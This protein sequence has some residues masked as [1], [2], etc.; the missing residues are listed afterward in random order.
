[1]YQEV[2]AAS[3]SPGGGIS[4]TTFSSCGGSGMDMR[5]TNRPRA[6]RESNCGCVHES[7]PRW[8]L[9]EGVGQP[10]WGT[11]AVQRVRC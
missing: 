6:S 4:Q 8:A 2:E 3:M 11:L 9:E 10:S 1:M 5:S 7:R